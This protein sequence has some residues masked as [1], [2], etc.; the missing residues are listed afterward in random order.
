MSLSM[1]QPVPKV[2][3]VI[4]NYRN[5]VDTVA[6]LQSLAHATY[7]RVETIVVDNDSRNNSLQRIGQDLESRGI[8]C[9]RLDEGEVGE[10]F[11]FRESVFLVQ[12][13]ANRGYAAGNNL[14]I[15]AALARGCD[16]VLILNND[17]EVQSDFLEPL[18]VYAEAHPELGAVGPKILNI[19]GCVERNCARRRPNLRFYF[20]ATGIGRKVWPNNPWSRGHHYEEEY[21]YDEPKSVDLL[22]G[23][24]MLLK[25]TALEQIG[26]FDET[27]FLYLE[28]LI[29]HEKFRSWG[30]RQAIVP[31]S[32]IMHKGGQTTRNEQPAHIQKA[33]RESLL[34]YL[35]HYRHFGWFTRLLI[36]W[37]VNRLPNFYSARR[38]T[39]TEIRPT[40]AQ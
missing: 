17:T 12:A 35:K 7:P 3:I 19:A 16:Y 22:S 4:L 20:F 36:D 25:G 37:N 31:A 21:D 23:S 30:W 10:C 27:T 18:V 8:P 13:S 14:G 9:A 33:A 2:G 15:R 38:R 5:F 28:E 34:Y 39:A 6:C 40:N 11:H 26:L 24:C 1:E 32:V 29:L